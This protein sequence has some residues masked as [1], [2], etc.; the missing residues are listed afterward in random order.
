MTAD[1]TKF[2]VQT[3]EDKLYKC[4]ATATQKN[5]LINPLS[6]DRGAAIAGGTAGEYGTFTSEKDGQSNDW[7]NPLAD[8]DEAAPFCTAPSDKTSPFACTK[9]KCITQRKMITGDIK[10]FMF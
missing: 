2:W 9:I 7:T 10:D 4:A 6:L 5:C 1:G 8:D 3:S